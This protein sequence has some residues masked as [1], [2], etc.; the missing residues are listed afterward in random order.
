MTRQRTKS[1][2]RTLNT[3][4]A[5]DMLELEEI[6]KLVKVMNKGMNSWGGTGRREAFK[7]HRYELKLHGRG[8]R[9]NPEAIAWRVEKNR[10][11]RRRNSYSQPSKHFPQEGPATEVELR[12]AKRQLR[13][14]LPVRFADSI[15]VY[16]HLRNDTPY[17][18]YHQR[19]EAALLAKSIDEVFA[20]FN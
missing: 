6:R 5:S 11:Y 15:D 18:V 8:S 1:Y 20:I 10:E 3:D 19:D 17:E 9:I 13:Q 2:V 7:Y 16:V 14:D 12:V 4:S